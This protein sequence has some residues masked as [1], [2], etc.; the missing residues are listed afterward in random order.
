MDN[1]LRW[2]SHRDRGSTG[3]QSESV[4]PNNPHIHNPSTQAA[5]GAPRPIGWS[6]SPSPSGSTQGQGHSRPGNPPHLDSHPRRDD[7]GFP[8][9]FREPGITTLASAGN[10]PITRTNSVSHA[11][12]G[13]LSSPSVE[14]DEALNWFTA[15]DQDGNG[16]LSYEELDSALSGLTNDSRPFS[17]TTVKYLMGIFD[18]DGNGVITFDEFGPLWDYL[19]D[20]QQMF[21]SFDTDRV[22]R[23]GT[24]ELGRAL[25]HYGIHLAPYIVDTIMKKYDKAPSRIW[26]AGHGVPAQMDRDHFILVCAVVRRI[27]DLYEKYI[28]GGQ[29]QLSRDD[30]LRA[31]IP[32]P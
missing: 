12:Q 7:L 1:L 24:P 2:F 21:D 28:A 23:I 8:G 14:R 6:S 17:A 29:T 32:L 31:V 22:G 19:N 3:P 27:C 18:R 20:G 26:Q 25:A 30:F 15:I 16:E 9:G 4:S 5:Q 11:L 13:V 10:Q